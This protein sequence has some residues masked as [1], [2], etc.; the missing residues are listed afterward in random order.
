[1][2]RVWYFII[3][4]CSKVIPVSDDPVHHAARLI[5]SGPALGVDGKEHF[6]PAAELAHHHHHVHPVLHLQQMGVDLVGHSQT[7]VAVHEVVAVAL[8]H[9]VASAA[10]GYLLA[11]DG[12]VGQPYLA[13]VH[14][15]D[16]VMDKALGLDDD[17]GE[18]VQA[19]DIVLHGMREDVLRHRGHRG[20]D[21]GTELEDFLVVG[22]LL[23]EAA[24]VGHRQV[25]EFLDAFHGGGVL[26]D[27][28][29]LVGD[30]VQTLVVLVLDGFLCGGVGGDLCDGLG[31]YD[32]APSGK[33]MR[34]GKREAGCGQSTA[35]L[36]LCCCSFASVAI[37]SLICPIVA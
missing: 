15:V 13:V 22:G 36:Y 3:V 25:V 16:E 5:D 18:L 37:F 17:I 21:V 32:K 1:M 20:E 14:H 26:Q 33:G 12:I 28:F 34:G 35:F 24:D 19:E 4:L 8:S 30:G 2:I 23:T 7:G 27:L 11:D 29:L 31:I 9:V 10:A 6:V